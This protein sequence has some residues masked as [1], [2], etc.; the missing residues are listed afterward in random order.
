MT[1]NSCTPDKPPKRWCLIEG[2]DKGDDYVGW[3]D[4]LIFVLMVL[5][6]ISAVIYMTAGNTPAFARSL[7][8]IGVCA[9]LCVSLFLRR[10]RNPPRS[11]YVLGGED[12]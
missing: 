6:V 3:R 4:V 2:S 5:C 8:T 12:R 7:H 9:G 1:S 11:A 10:R